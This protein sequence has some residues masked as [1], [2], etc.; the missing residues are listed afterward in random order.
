MEIKKT[1]QADLTKKSWLYFNIGLFLTMVVIVSAF[2]WKTFDDA[3][4][5]DLGMVNE[6]MED[7]LDIPLTDIPPPPPPKV[8]QPEIIDI[9]DDEEIED[10]IELDLDV[11]ITEDKVIEKIVFEAAPEEEDTD[12]IFL[13]VEE[14]ASFPGGMEAWANYLRKNMK[15]P[16]QARRMGIEGR[17]FL[18]FVVDEKGK[19][20]N[21]E[22]LRGIGGGC[23]EEAVRVLQN[24]PNWS[25]GK[26]RG[27]AVKSYMQLA[28]V[29]KLN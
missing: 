1:E 9:P 19:V 23:D 16:A 8:Q 29:F 17:V 27:R 12:Q 13:V 10:E 4:L 6:D 20:S 24:A 14:Q 28:I 5:A 3:G 25:P 2:E 22:I 21:I 7:L 15:Y 18:K 11:E 26:Q